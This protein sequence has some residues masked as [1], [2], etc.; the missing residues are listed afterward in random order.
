M[1]ESTW[2]QQMIFAFYKKD[3]LLFIN[4]LFI[5]MEKYAYSKN[6]LKALFVRIPKAY[7]SFSL[8]L[9][10][11]CFPV[12]MQAQNQTISGTV[13]DTADEP[14]IGV[15]VIVKG[16]TT[17]TI[18]DIDG[19]FSLTAQQ[20]STL[21]ISYM[22]YET[23]EIKVTGRA[24]LDIRLRE[25]R[26]VLDEVVV[27]GFGTQKK[28]SLTGAVGVIDGEE[29]ES[30]PV[31]N[32]VQA[33]QGAVPGLNISTQ[34]IGGTLNAGRSINVRGTGTIA[35]DGSGL[36][37]SGSPLVLVDGMEG[38]LDA[39]NPQDI[40]NISVLKDAA[41]AAVYG[42][43]APFGVIL[44]TTK[45]GR[46]GRTQIS[47]NNSFRWS[48]PVLRQ[49]MMSSYEFVN[50]WNDADRNG[51]GSGQKFKPAFVQRVKD[52]MDG[53]LD[54]SDVVS[55]PDGNN[56]ITGGR[57]NYD[58]T[59]AN[60]DWMKQYYRDSAPAQEHTISMNGGS[61]KWRY[62]VSGNYLDQEGLMRYGT[63]TFNRYA[64]T[65]K[66]SGELYS[67]LQMDYTNRFVRT[68][69][70]R[71][72]T[73]EDGFYEHIM[74]RAR[75]IR[76]ITDPNGYYMS[77][78]NY[79]DAL[80]NGGR[81][82]EQKDWY[83]QQF[84]LTFTPLKD[85]NIIGEINYRIYNE[86]IHEDA[87][88]VYSYDAEGKRMKD[89]ALTSVSNDYVYEFAKKEYF[90][91]P[92]IYSDYSKSMG[93]HNFKALV[94]FQYEKSRY[95]DLSASR[96]D[97]ISTNIPVINQTTNQTPTV[98]GQLQRW[99]TAGFFGRIN[100]DYEN[101]YL[102][103][104]N[105]RYDGTSRFRKDKRWN[106]FPS[107]SLGW[108]IA[109]E[110]FW[111]PVSPIVGTLKL[112]ASY[113]KLGNQ[114][115]RDWYPTYQTI[116]TGVANGNWLIGGAKPNT[117]G[118]PGLVSTSL[119]W[120]KISSWNFGAD[121]GL[122]NNRLTGSFDYFVRDTKD[123]MGAGPTLPAVL[124]TSVPRVNNIDIRTS[125]FELSIAWRDKINEFSYGVAFN[126]SDSK[127]KVTNYY[128][129]TGRIDDPLTG[130]Y[131]GEIWGF[132]TI[133]IAKTQEEMDAHLASLP[134]GGQSAVGNRWEAGDIMYADINNDG[135]ISEGA[136]T[137][138]DHGDLK[139]I[140]NNNPR[141]AVGMNLNA[142]WKGIDFGMFWQGILK[143]DYAPTGM[144]FWG[145]TSA[146]EWW[147]TAMKPHLDYFRT[148]ES[149]LGE[150]LD[151]YYPRPVWG[152]KNQKAQTRYL[153]DASYL[154]LKNIQLGYTLPES[155]TQ[156]FKVSKLRVF[157]SG[158][159]L[160]TITD[161]NDTLDPESIGIG[162]QGGTTYPLQK[163][164][165]FGL[166]ANF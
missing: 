5:I 150:N 34:G 110:K 98:T 106:W 19:K 143:R 153:L 83:T 39:L 107:F 28:V 61:E 118:A 155:F 122:F 151:S 15:S 11:L 60:V 80:E 44:V 24:S 26:K 166:S 68:D 12:G 10:L 65:L 42:S 75:P 130:Y 154:R 47:Y 140:G 64:T 52:Y 165:S 163:T 142:S 46:A 138:S 14:L 78:I 86:G 27:V 161:L 21:V 113:G 4:L 48:S 7:F 79:I 13:V 136:R 141:Y 135:K 131:T 99:A 91:N 55:G 76:A 51:G 66:I 90:F 127:T 157:I 71:A 158:E 144:M 81:R 95:N 132:Q 148:S 77:D 35:K 159:N 88:K 93:G 114:N 111:E 33:L 152:D 74:R 97:M 94:G 30:R 147:S 8:I 73:M 123:G 117:A 25:D 119:T 57:W 164:I 105:L 133:G 160:L 63:D 56:P 16:T 17:G 149:L 22:G 3:N 100:Y 87:F 96:K 54:P 53:K 36:L 89:Q 70:K 101:R 9:I 69:Y 108:N 82:K 29:L 139:I 18:T 41:S 6:K 72:T 67:G 37:S 116:P 50:F 129:E 103:E 43:R 2:L 137:L 45:K 20:G 102:F 49:E 31:Q 58:Y 109:Q 104:A 120:E 85:W 92:N 126:L 125:G 156:R 134:E 84:K 38:D 128:N 146:G 124:G 121:W 115:M 1:V 32:A 23:Q 162:K 145:I 112:R 62:Y 59:N 40:E